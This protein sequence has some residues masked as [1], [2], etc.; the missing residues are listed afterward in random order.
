MIY[1]VGGVI[2]PSLGGLALDAWPHRGL[3]VLVASAASALL[4]GIAVDATR[5]SRLLPAR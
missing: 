5:R 2:G 1:C 3:P 4:V